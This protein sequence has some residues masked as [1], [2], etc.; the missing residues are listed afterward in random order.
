M[1]PSLRSGIKLRGCLT[2][3]ILHLAMQ[4]LPVGPCPVPRVA[5]FT[6]FRPCGQHP[7]SARR[8][9]SRLFLAVQTRSSRRPDVRSST[10]Q[11][12]NANGPPSSAPQ[13][14]SSSGPDLAA[15]PNPRTTSATEPSPCGSDSNRDGRP[16]ASSD[17]LRLAAT[18]SRPAALR[19][20]FPYGRLAGGPEIPPG[21]L[22]APT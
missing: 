19:P 10:F 16:W 7:V 3:S 20:A 21:I 12:W 15:G 1:N 18:L 22:P 9:G 6:E 4:P 8:F 17:T 11:R 14:V 2:G 13:V 5:P